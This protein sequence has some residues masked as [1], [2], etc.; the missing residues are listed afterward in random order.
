MKFG[1]GN[2]AILS[3]YPT[4]CSR[5]AFATRLLALLLLPS[6][7]TYGDS[8][9][10]GPNSHI[11]R[12]GQTAGMRVTGEYFHEP[13]FTQGLVFVDGFLFESTGLF[14]ES[15]LRKVEPETGRELRRIALPPELFGEG[16][17]SLGDRLYQLTWRS[18]QG[19]IYDRS[20]LQLIGTFT[21]EGEGWGLTTDG[22]DL[23]MSDGSEFV[24]FL[25]VETYK[26]LRRLR[27]R[28]GNVPVDRLNELEF[29]EGYIYAN[30]WRDD[31]ILKIDPTDG[32]VVAHYDL[33]DLMA[34]ERRKAPEIILNG[35]AH[36]SATGR[37]FITGKNW[38]KL[39]AVSF[40]PK[41]EAE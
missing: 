7:T 27:V 5:R 36:D 21:Y 8:R 23:I 41:R 39:L 16:L 33:S 11:Q 35:I 9:P 2:P 10:P 15:S 25:D 37:V 28:Q 14:G 31:V 12:A 4:H 6:L 29:I 13:V 17:T 34:A 38:S 26:E 3:R 24:R 19:R 18:G 22:R 40:E 30:V 1:I 20:T 32:T